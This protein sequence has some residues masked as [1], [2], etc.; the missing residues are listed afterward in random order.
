MMLKKSN[1]I[2]ILKIYPNVALSVGI[3]KE[4]FQI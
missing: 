4:D 3:K 2:K 1:K